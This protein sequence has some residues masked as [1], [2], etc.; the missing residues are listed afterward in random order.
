MG[1]VGRQLSTSGES[2][3]IISRS[4][5]FVFDRMKD[6]RQQYDVSLKVLG[7]CP[8]GIASRHDLAMEGGERE[9][10]TC[11]ACHATMPCEEI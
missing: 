9:M 5:R 11:C 10:A 4:M 1:T 2:D 3:G 6:I 8:P 7:A